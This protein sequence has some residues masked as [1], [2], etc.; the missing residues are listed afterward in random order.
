M[1]IIIIL[2]LIVI[3]IIVTVVGVKCK[4]KFTNFPKKNIGLFENTPN[5][6][7][8]YILY[9]I[10]NSPYQQ[11]QADLLDFSVAVSGQPGKIIRTVS[12]DPKFPNRP[13]PQS[14][15]GIT[16]KTE[17]FGKY[18]DGYYALN[19]SGSLKK[20]R[21]QASN[22]SEHIPDNAVILLLD[23][24]MIF[25][26]AWDPRNIVKKGIVYGQ[27]WHGY[28]ENYCRKIVPE[29][30][31][32]CPKADENAIMYPFAMTMGDLEKIVPK[33]FQ[34]SKNYGT[35]KDWMTDM[36]ALV[37]S[38]HDKSLGLKVITEQ[39]I[40]IT[41]DWLNL[42]Q[43]PEA[44]IMH[45]CQTIKDSSKKEI[46]SKRKYSAWEDVPDPEQATNRVDREVLKMIRKFRIQQSQN[47]H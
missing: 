3:I 7:P 40:G 27:R 38:L 22:L 11:W 9:S 34:G 17:D 39:N 4:D 8:L 19:K 18:G 44:P 20:I 12:E 10:S 14:R 15:N 13:I 25:T 36:S 16:I 21:E 30:K 31:D 47:H 29:Y 2:L 5:Q 23:P 46:W 37:I 32:D 35:T 42:N 28:G 26:K 45:Y 6:P 1:G 33:Y 41:N 24:D 43:D